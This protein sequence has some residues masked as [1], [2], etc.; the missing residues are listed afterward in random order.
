MIT[1]LYLH[2]EVLL[3]ALRDEKG[4]TE[5]GA[6]HSQ[7]V[8]AGAML[9]ELLLAKRISF[10]DSKKHLVEVVSTER[11]DASSLADGVLGDALMQMN[12]AKP[13]K[14]L[15]HWVQK[16][17][18][19][20]KL[21]ERIADGLCKKG[22]LEEQEVL[23]LGLFKTRRFPEK[24]P[25]PERQLIQ[26]L[27]EVIFSDEEQLDV[28]TAILISLTWKSEILAIPFSSKALRKRK[29]RIEQI[30]NGE[31]VGRATAEVIQAIQAITTIAA[32]MPAI[33]ASTA[34]C[35]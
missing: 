27:E 8:L 7:H 18:S 32:I 3:L 23:I 1:P 35:H 16:L 24:D 30:V 29:E 20:R 17:A 13:P 25:E 4:T 21:T 19:M 28:R 10:D 31:L 9:A 15:Q 2:E 6:T 22:V 12:E 14:P 26:R 34:S 11:L 5:W 33:T